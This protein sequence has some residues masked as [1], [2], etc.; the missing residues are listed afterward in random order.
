MLLLRLRRRRWRR[1]CRSHT[2]YGLHRRCRGSLQ[3]FARA[4]RHCG[5]S[6]NRR[7]RA[8]RSRHCR[9]LRRR[10]VRSRYGGSELNAPCKRCGGNVIEGGG[11][12]GRR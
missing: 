6:G 5:N 4:V 1:R 12:G 3:R 11:G 10:Q 7:L 8:P 2:L 9:R